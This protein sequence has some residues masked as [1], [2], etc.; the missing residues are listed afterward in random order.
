MPKYYHTLES[1]EVMMF[2]DQYWN[3]FL[4][5]WIPITN[6][7][8]SEK[9]GPMA[10]RREFTQADFDPEATVCLMIDSRN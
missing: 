3:K 4:A 6:E 1:Y 10:V 8:I 2:G 5:K 9:V 7:M